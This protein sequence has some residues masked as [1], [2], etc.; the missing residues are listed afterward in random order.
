M[1][2]NGGKY[3]LPTFLASVTVFPSMIRFLKS[4]F[5]NRECAIVPLIFHVVGISVPV[6]RAPVRC[7][8]ILDL[9]C[10]DWSHYQSPQERAP[11]PD[12]RFLCTCGGSRE[13][14]IVDSCG[15]QVRR[16]FV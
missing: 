5:S 10:G 3:F 15:S 16:K 11:C 7:G 4:L 9:V 2:N 14:I 12:Q 8:S 1:H 6:T 13:R